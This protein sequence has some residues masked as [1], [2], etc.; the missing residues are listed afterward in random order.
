MDDIFEWI[1]TF[2]V[3]P[4]HIGIYFKGCGPAKMK[5]VCQPTTVKKII[6][7]TRTCFCFNTLGFYQDTPP[8][9]SHHSNTESGAFL[10]LPYLTDS[11]PPP[12]QYF[13]YFPPLMCP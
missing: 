8:F 5:T 7:E 1:V 13:R 2:S 3:S 12:P 4:R 10:S 6:S 9:D 11:P